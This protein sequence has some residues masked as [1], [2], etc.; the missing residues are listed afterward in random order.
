MKSYIVL[1]GKKMKKRMVGMQD[2]LWTKA[3][4]KVEWSLMLVILRVFGFKGK[5]VG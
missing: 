1:K 2:Q 4:N 5:F 3:Y